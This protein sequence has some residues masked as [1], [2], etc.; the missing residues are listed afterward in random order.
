ML[1]TFNN[2]IAAS[3]LTKNKGSSIPYYKCFETLIEKNKRA[4]IPGYPSHKPR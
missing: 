1:D 3:A 2:Q 4:D